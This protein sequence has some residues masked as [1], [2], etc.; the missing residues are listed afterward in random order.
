MK[1]TATAFIF[2]I[3]AAVAT[4]VPGQSVPAADESTI[5]FYDMGAAQVQF[6]TEKCGLRTL[7]VAYQIEHTSAQDA[8]R[9]LAYEPKLES[10]VFSALSDYLMT[11]KDPRAGAVQRVI[12]RAI[13]Q[14]LGERMVQDILITDIQQVDS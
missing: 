9:I 8:A 13:Q 7:L 3:V 6:E 1:I 14:T 11:K 10:V 12:K 5:F 4:L 2:G